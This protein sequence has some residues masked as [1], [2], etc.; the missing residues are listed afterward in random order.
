MSLTSG[1]SCLIYGSQAV[2]SLLFIDYL[3]IYE[4]ACYEKKESVVVAVLIKINCCY[5]HSAPI[6]LF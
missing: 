4:P 1:E 6:L 3:L 2:L 5:Y